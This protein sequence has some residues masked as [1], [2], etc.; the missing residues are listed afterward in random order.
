MYNIKNYFTI[1]IHIF[2]YI[3]IM[4]IQTV[5]TKKC[6]KQLDS[7]YKGFFH[8]LHVGEREI[9]IYIIK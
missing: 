6:T 1:Y 8:D 7:T 9:Y 5:L 4:Y 3:C 2:I